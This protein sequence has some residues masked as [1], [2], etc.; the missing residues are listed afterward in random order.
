[1]SWK[2]RYQQDNSGFAT[3]QPVLEKILSLIDK[4]ILELGCGEGSTELIDHYAKQKNLKVVT[5]ESEKSWMEK[6]IHLH[7]DTHA[8]MCIENLN[9]WAGYFT[10]DIR[11]WGLVFIDQGEWISRQNCLTALKDKTDYI[12]LHDSCYYIKNKIFGNVLNQ[13]TEYACS[14]KYPN[15]CP[16]C[17][18]YMNTSK[19][20][21]SDILKY[22][23]EYI[24]PYG[25]P[26][27]LGSEKIDISDLI[28][29]MN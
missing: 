27:L 21:Y 22:H 19:R 17:C 15:N 12:I 25:P 1:M 26:T 3:H 7:S 14:F 5:V 11:T 9:E 2:G 23:K 16:G 13:K 28:I 4:P 6:Y 24:S 29:D 10:S 18:H 20:D 8:F